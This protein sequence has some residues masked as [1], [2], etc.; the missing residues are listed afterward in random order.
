MGVII[1][2]NFPVEFSEILTQ[3]FDYDGVD[4]TFSPTE[5]PYSIV[6]V[7]INQTPIFNDRY[8]FANNAVTIDDDIL[9]E[10]DKV[11][12]TYTKAI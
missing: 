1:T 7:V 8:T 9:Y 6:A 12:I 5:K 4:N 11:Y 3:T 10:N 2:K